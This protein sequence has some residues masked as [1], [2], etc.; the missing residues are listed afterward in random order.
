V[1]ILVSC[2]HDGCLKIIDGTWGGIDIDSII[3]HRWDVVGLN[4]GKEY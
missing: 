4:R 1:L 2:M 3:G